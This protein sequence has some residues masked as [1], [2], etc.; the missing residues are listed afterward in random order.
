M[1]YQDDYRVGE[2]KETMEPYPNFILSSGCDLPLETPLDNIKS[3]V[4]VV[5]TPQAV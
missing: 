4:Q 2:V 1:W 5:K 3:M